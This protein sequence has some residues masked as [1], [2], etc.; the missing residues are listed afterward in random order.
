MLEH[1][2]ARA[3]REFSD[4]TFRTLPSA[5]LVAADIDVIMALFEANYREANRAYLE[6]S[7]GK[8][9]YTTIATH[10]RTP[11]AFALG[12]ARVIDL[13][14]LPAQ[15]V[16]LAGICCVSPRFRRRGL[17]AEVEARSI[18]ASDVALPP[19]RRFLTC[20]RMAHPASFR[21]MARNPAVVPRP[22]AAPTEWHQ[23][24]GIAIA[25]AYGVPE[26][27][28]Q[29]F[30]CKGTGVPIGYPVMEVDATPEEW[31]M[32]RYVDRSRGDSLLGIAWAP[33]APEGW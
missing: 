30:V 23:A 13:P 7:L 28:A 27:D 3:H 25:G 26:F 10:A 12:E 29:T 18:R 5:D 31:E 20:G 9:K 2:D 1:L 6:R 4:F 33:D 15:I 21:L 14:R 19:G 8:L 24:V 16:T 32:F 22:G 17:F 11:A